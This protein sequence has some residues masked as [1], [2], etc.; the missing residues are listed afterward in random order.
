[1]FL[2]MF[3]LM[4]VLAIVLPPPPTVGEALD[5]ADEDDAEA[6]DEADDEDDA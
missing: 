3:T 6:P 5:S 2:L 1:M 4:Y